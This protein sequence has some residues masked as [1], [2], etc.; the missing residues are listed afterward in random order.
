MITLCLILISH[1]LLLANARVHDH[2]RLL[3]NDPDFISKICNEIL[4]D[5][6]NCT[7]ILRADPRVLQAAVLKLA[8][9]KGIE[10]KKFLDKI[11]ERGSS[12]AL[13]ECRLADYVVAVANLKMALVDLK[14]D[15]QSAIH[16]AKVAAN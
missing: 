15:P 9:K 4:H 5:K 12:V 2:D 6:I 1:S 7:K 13:A 10:G 14:H 16:D 8:L 3:G 11:L